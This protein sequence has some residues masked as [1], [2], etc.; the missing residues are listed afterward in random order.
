MSRKREVSE[1]DNSNSILSIK[2]TLVSIELLK[3]HEEVD[4]V[5]HEKLKKTIE[6]VKVL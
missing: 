6:S 3:A 5:Y 2:P 1:S 4:K